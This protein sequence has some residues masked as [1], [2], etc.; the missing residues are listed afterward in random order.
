MIPGMTLTATDAFLGSIAQVVPVFLIAGI[1][2]S[3]LL[4]RATKRMNKDFKKAIARIL[5]VSKADLGSVQFPMSLIL[6]QFRAISFFVKWATPLSF[7]GLFGLV[8]W[9][10]Y[11]ALYWLGTDVADRPKNLTSEM[12]T[13]AI[14]GIIFTLMPRVFLFSSKLRIRVLKRERNPN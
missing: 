2:D 14:A 13:F 6:W 9:V 7:W 10:E 8:A 3:A 1:V 11:H 12:L 4:R 5:G